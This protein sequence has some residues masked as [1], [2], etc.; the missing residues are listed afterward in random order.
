MVSESQDD[1]YADD[2][3]AWQVNDLPPGTV[4]DEETGV[5]EPDDQDDATE[6][7]EPV[8]VPA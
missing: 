4:D 7:N 8:K 5:P 1:I 2:S 6:P 3:A